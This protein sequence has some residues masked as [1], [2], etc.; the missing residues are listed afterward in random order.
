MQSLVTRLPRSHG[1]MSKL[2]ASLRYSGEGNRETRPRNRRRD[3][4]RRLVT[5]LAERYRGREKAVNDFTRGYLAPC[6][7]RLDQQEA[8]DSTSRWRT[9]DFLLSFCDDAFRLVARFSIPWKTL[10]GCPELKCSKIAFLCDFFREE[11]KKRSCW[12]LRY[13]FIYI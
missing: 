1:K 10:K 12:I 11:R 13:G 7:D 2:A 8:T 6:S 5:R 4:R 3:F 9:R